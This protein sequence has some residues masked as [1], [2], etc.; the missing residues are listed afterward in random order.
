MSCMKSYVVGLT[1]GIGS[2]KSA[3][4]GAFAALG[5]AIVDTDSIA[6]ALTAPDGAALPALRAAFGTE[7]FTPDGQLDR[8][9]L[10]RLVFAEPAARTRLENMLH[11]LIRAEAESQLCRLA[12]ADFSYIVLVVPLL[13]E[14]CGWRDCI[15][16]IVV[17]D[18]PEEMQIQRVMAR[19]AYSRAE[20]EAI[21]AAQAP[22]AA[23][24]AIAND[25]IVNDGSP[26][27]LQARVLGLHRQY[28]AAA[29]CRHKD[30]S[31]DAV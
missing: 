28:L 12:T 30:Q 9:T 13:A 26:A 19:N 20:V 17:V 7:V 15:D 14:T 21:M 4:A 23:R 25:V 10:R 29:A 8:A 6:H 31:G 3:A 16:R 5:A 1:G 2:G 11:P 22:R 27:D 18:C 24:L